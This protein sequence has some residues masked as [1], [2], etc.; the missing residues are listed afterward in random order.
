MHRFQLHQELVAVY[1][2]LKGLVLTPQQAARLK[3]LGVPNAL[4]TL[5][6]TWAQ[7]LATAILGGYFVDADALIEVTELVS[8]DAEGYLYFDG[9]RGDNAGDGVDP[10]SFWS[11]LQAK[12]KA[13]EQQC[14]TAML[15]GLTV[16]Q[17]HQL[18]FFKEQDHA[19]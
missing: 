4:S 16:Q 12:A 17:R 6:L 1:P 9:I 7:S 10:M 11:G 5:E 2:G 8:H 13:F 3:S 15:T 14:L 18:S 19:H